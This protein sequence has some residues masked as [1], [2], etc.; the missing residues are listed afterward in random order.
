MG[1]LANHYSSS[2]DAVGL[3]MK[4]DG[5]IDVDQDLLYRSAEVGDP[6]TNLGA[7]QNFANALI[8]KSN[9]VSL[10]P[11]EYTNQVMVAYKNPGKNF[12]DPYN[13]SIYT[14]MMFSSYC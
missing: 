11:M 3:S 9:E 6:K 14:G 5:T 10:N 4:T 1:A 2:L 13:T 12:P 7:V 8:R